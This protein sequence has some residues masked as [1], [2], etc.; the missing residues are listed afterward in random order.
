MELYN[1]ANVRSFLDAPDGKVTWNFLFNKYVADFPK[2]TQK[3]ARALNKRYF[4]KFFGDIDDV[5]KIDS[6]TVIN[7]FHFRANYWKNNQRDGHNQNY[8][9]EVNIASL[10]VDSTIL[11][12]ILTRAFNDRFVYQMPSFPT[13]KELEKYP[14]VL[15]IEIKAR[16][17]RFKTFISEDGSIK[18]EY[19]TTILP[20]LRNIPNQAVK[21]EQ[22][23]G[24]RQYRYSQFGLWFYLL[25]IS[26]TAIRPQEMK[27]LKFSDFS[28]YRD[29]KE[30]EYTVILIRRNVAK[31]GVTR[32][33]IARDMG[34][35]F[36]RLQRWKKETQLYWGTA[37][38]PNDLV[39][40]NFRSKLKPRSMMKVVRTFH[41]K[42]GIHSEVIDG[43][44]VY[45]TAYS[46]RSL[47]ISMMLTD[48][49]DIFS[50]ARN[51]GS[52]VSTLE[53]YYD[54]SST[55]SHRETLTKQIQQI[56]IKP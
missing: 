7:Y 56:A 16:R 39:F 43:T 25:T 53:K 6:G 11:K 47:C 10:T 30:N 14:D 18:N 5:Y 13:V 28:L 27:K 4:V 37:A 31:T 23:R 20:L 26:N 54:V 29:Q 22:G 41:N 34:D 15:N 32:E 19:T 1:E 49:V 46:Y 40:P 42:T 8:P 36:K 38:K 35:T 48:G 45:L 17:K 3:K 12:K 24:G 50:V 55:L 44:P 21:S 52:G 2:S 51:A 9:Q 33:V